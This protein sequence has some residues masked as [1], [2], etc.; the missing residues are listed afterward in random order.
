MTVS[1]PVQL[2]SP[3]DITSAFDL[4]S[5]TAVTFSG[6]ITG[7]VPINV[8]G[9]GNVQISADSPSY[10]GNITVNNGALRISG[11]YLTAAGSLTVNNGG[12]FQFG[13]STDTDWSL[14]PGDRW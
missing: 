2:N 8:Y 1:A 10:T 4:A 6:G 13:S 5:N 3:L 11:D 9:G 7:N 12:Q 14:A